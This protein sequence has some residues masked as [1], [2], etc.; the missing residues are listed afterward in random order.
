MK[1]IFIV[2]LAMLTIGFMACKQQVNQPKTPNEKKPHPRQRKKQK[3][4]GMFRKAVDILNEQKIIYAV[5]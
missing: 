3:I 1:S 4:F 5:C 2:G